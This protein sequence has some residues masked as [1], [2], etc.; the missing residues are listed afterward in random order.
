MKQ[1]IDKINRGL[2]LEG[3]ILNTRMDGTEW[4]ESI[5]EMTMPKVPEKRNA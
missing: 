4:V 3:W 5:Q 2:I 1:I